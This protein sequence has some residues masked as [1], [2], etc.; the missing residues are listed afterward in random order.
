MALQSKCSV[1]DC[2][3]NVAKKGLCTKHYHR[4]HRHG[5]T[6][7]TRASDWGKREKHPLYSLWAGLKRYPVKQVCDEWKNDF[8]LFVSDVGERP[9]GMFL[10][11]RDSSKPISKENSVWVTRQLLYENTQQDGRNKYLREYRKLNPEWFQK[12]DAFKK[13]G[14]TGEQYDEMFLRQNNRCAICNKEEDHKHHST[15]KV[16]K[17]AIDHCHKTGKVRGLLCTSCNHGLG[18]FKD[19]VELLRKAIDYLTN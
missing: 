8:W 18:R 6:E 13:Y 5:S 12:N 1:T 9:N 17:L 14:L 2:D 4:V 11:A 10:K 16:R 3:G 7:Q 15:G 19:D